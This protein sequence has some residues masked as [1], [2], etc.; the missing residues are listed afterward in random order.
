MFLSWRHLHTV[1]YVCLRVRRARNCASN[2]WGVNATTY[3]LLLSNCRPCPV[4]M[5][6][7][8]NATAYPNSASYYVNNGDGTGGF[9]SKWA[10]V[11]RPGYGFNGTVGR[12]F[13]YPCAK[14]DYNSGDNWSVCTQ[15]GYGLTTLA[16]GAGV[17][18]S[19]CGTAP[20]FGWNGTSIIQCPKGECHSMIRVQQL[21]L[22]QLGQSDW[23][24]AV[25]LRPPHWCADV[26]PA[27]ACT[28]ASMQRKAA[29][30]LDTCVRVSFAHLHRYSRFSL[31]TATD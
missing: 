8:T 10:C 4:N 27:P 6:T 29:L 2:Q 15:C 7:S 24:A 3:D 19:D 5:V 11:T 12:G 25:W 30:G 22:A 18:F 17:R 13:S 9:T 23:Q 16:A 26:T 1:S 21:Q 31:T 20:G 14:G 28:Q